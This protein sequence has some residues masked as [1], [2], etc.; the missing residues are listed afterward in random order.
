MWRWASRSPAVATP[1]STSWS[2]SS[3]TPW[4]CAS[5]SAAIPTVAELLAQVRARSLAAFE[6]QDVPFELLVE[7]L[8][9]TRSLTHHPLVQVMLAWQNIAWHGQ[10]PAAHMALGDLD[11]TPHAGRHPSRPHGSGVLA[12][13]TLDRD[14]RA[15]GH[16][17]DGGVPHRRVRR[18]TIATLVERLQRVLLAITDEP[19][20]ELSSIDLLDAGE[21]ARLDLIGNRAALT[22]PA[23]PAT[24][25]PDVVRRTRAARP[26][27]VAVTSGSRSMT[28]S[29]LDEA[30]NRLAHLLVRHGA[31]PG[32]CVALLFERS[33]EAI[34]AILAVLKTGAAY[35]PID[36]AS[37]AARIGVRPRR[38]R[39]D[40]R[41]HHRRPCARDSTELASR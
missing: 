17:R 19:G 11:V 30:S 8:N 33:A 3:S 7:R 21:R 36:P 37:P 9:P 28:Y 26:E 4:C 34:V 23:S 1:R 12:G 32:Q 29:E 16:R 5:T 41:G 38:C 35:L 18:G 40:R 31:G 24:S 25:V 10:D 6:H 13:R 22:R 2:A 14:R 39:S 20:R 15:R 27:A